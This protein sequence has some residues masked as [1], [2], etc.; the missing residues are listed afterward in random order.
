MLEEAQ[1][2]SNRHFCVAPWVGINFNPSG[3]V[4][5]CHYYTQETPVG[6]LSESSVEE[7]RN[8]PAMKELRRN[9]LADKP[10]QG[11]RQ[12]Y[13]AEEMGSHSAFLGLPEMEA[14]F[15][16]TTPDGTLTDDKV[17][18]LH[19][20]FSNVCN[21]KCRICGP[22]LSSSWR[23]D[24]AKLTGGAP[25]PIMRLRNTYAGFWESVVAMAPHLKEIY[26]WG[27]EP[28]LMPE[29][30]DFLEVLREANNTLVH[31][32]YTTNFS[33]LQHG[34]FDAVAAWKDFPNVSV[35]ASLDGMG[36]RGELMRKGQN[37]VDVENNLRELRE[38]APHVY[39]F[40]N[41]TVS[42]M[43]AW[44]V[45][46][47]HR[48][49][50]E[51][52]LIEPNDFVVSLLRDPLEL[53]PEVLPPEFR[54]EVLHKV[55]RYIDDY[56]AQMPKDTATAQRRFGA[57]AQ[58]LESCDGSASIPQFLKYMNRLDSIRGESW[59]TIFPELALAFA[60]Y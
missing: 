34:K 25:P 29:H 33:S 3:D 30:A 18:L 35:A 54:T 50:V 40:L 49:W 41:C 11:C 14:V 36:A 58:C 4:Y 26:F 42:A 56:L 28:L 12:C 47:F 13:F 39:F 19:V 8:S 6:R 17:L 46:D 23:A 27:G 59:K 57:L 9:I 2:R 43:N 22:R 31:L 32:R 24:S 44:H 7:I 51:R 48:D 15:A 16:A 60:A 10:T 21:F 55:R 5:P 53:R 20:Q 37:W 38:G 52:D 45:T 1:Q